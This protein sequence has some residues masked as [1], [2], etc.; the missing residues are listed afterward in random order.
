MERKFMMATKAKHITGNL[1]SDKPDLCVIG[2]ETSKHYIGNWFT[3]AGFFDVFFP[4]ETT[5]ELTEEEIK[6]YSGKHVML[7]SSYL[8]QLK[9]KELRNEVVK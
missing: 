7:N 4:K 9:E 6:Y 5:R 2:A 8:G 1:S 3:G